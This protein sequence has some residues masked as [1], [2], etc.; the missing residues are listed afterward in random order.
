[1]RP[2]V[3]IGEDQGSYGLLA[4]EHFVAYLDM[5]QSRREQAVLDLDA[6]KLQMVLVVGA[7]DAV[8]AQSRLVIDLQSDHGEM[9]VFEA[10]LRCAFSLEAEQ[11]VVPVLDLGNFGWGDG[12][13][14]APRYVVDSSGRELWSSRGLSA[15]HSSRS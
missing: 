5:L 11:A 9:T 7:G 13:H 4:Q 3:K 8:G 1:L 15:S 12:G 10:E 2:G 6:Q 14:G